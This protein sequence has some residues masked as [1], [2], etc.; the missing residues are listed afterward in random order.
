[1][2][3]LAIFDTNVLIKDRQDNSYQAC[4]ITNHTGHLLWQRLTKNPLDTDTSVV[5]LFGPDSW[6]TINILHNIS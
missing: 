3:V 4:C 1:M 2:V 6:Y 5:D